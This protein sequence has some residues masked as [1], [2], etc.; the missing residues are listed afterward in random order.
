VNR[1]NADRGL[2]SAAARTPI[3]RQVLVSLGVGGVAFLVTNVLLDTNQLKQIW[4]LALSIFIGGVILITQFLIDFEGRLATVER[5]QERHSGELRTGFSQINEATELFGL[6]E[7]SALRTDAVIQLIRH[8]TQID[9]S[10]P[11]LVFRFAQ[12]E[13]SRM[14]EF[15][16][17]LSDGGDVRYEGEDRDWMLS[18]AR[19]AGSS[20]DAT[21]LITVDFGRSNVADGGLWASDLGQRYLKEQR[22]AIQKGVQIR[23]V[24]V[25]DEPDLEGLQTV[26][27]MQQDIGISVRILDLSRN[28]GI[29]RTTLFDSLFDFVVFDS[30]ISYEVT[31]ASPIG[32]TRP[33]IV[34]TR[35]ELRSNRVK[36]RIQHFNDLWESAE[37]PPGRTAP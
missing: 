13:I 37:P 17:E 34:N 19:H 33:T 14:S 12:A 10:A 1:P 20:I 5:M 11:S 29:R 27:K 28:N 24:F 9:P 26:C 22:A 32:D 18:L 16:K 8:S 7:A 36:D 30:A 35:L 2:L 23:R 25:T 31:P 3:L 6:V 15:L 4:S 21:S